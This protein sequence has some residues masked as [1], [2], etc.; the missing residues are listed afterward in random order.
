MFGDQREM[1]SLLERIPFLADFVA[2]I[3]T[4]YPLE[5]HGCVSNDLQVRNHCRPLRGHLA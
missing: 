2:T 1:G 4:L 3:R 5:S